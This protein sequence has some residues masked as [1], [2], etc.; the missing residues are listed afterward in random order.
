MAD[1]FNLDDIKNFDTSKYDGEKSLSFNL[2]DIL[3]DYSGEKTPTV[4][5]K[6]VINETKPSIDDTGNIKRPDGVSLTGAFEAI[7]SEKETSAQ[8]EDDTVIV[9]E[10]NDPSVKEEKP[11]KKD[12]KSQEITDVIDRKRFFDTE[13]FN[14]IKKENREL[15]S[16][17]IASFE[18]YTEEEDDGEEEYFKPHEPTEEIDDYNQE[19][20]RDDIMSDLKK[21][22]SSA[23]FK[24]FATFIFMCIS[25]ILF[26]TNY[27]DFSLPRI[28]PIT[29]AKLYIS[30][31]FGISVLSTLININAIITGVGGLFK[32][33]CIPETFISVIFIFNSVVNILTLI[34]DTTSGSIFTF[35]FIY[36]LLLFFNIFSKGIMAKNILKNFRIVSSDGQKMVVNKSQNDELIND[37]MIETESTGDII[38][39]TKSEFVTDFIHKSF[40]DFDLCHRNTMFNTFSL[41]IILAIGII[42]YFTIGDLRTAFIYVTGAFC[43]FTPILQAFS[44]AVPVFNNSRKAR[45]NGGVI[46]GSSSS[47][48]LEDAQTVIVDDSDVFNVT[49][50]GIRL[51][52]DASIDETIIYLNSLFGKVGG[53]LKKLFSDMVTDENISIPRI[54]EIYY[55]ET[56]GYSSLIHSKVFVVGNKQLMNHFGIE[57]DDSDFDIIYQQKNKHVLF[58]AYNGKLVGVF[59]LSYSLC[60]GVKKAFELC[61]Q[62]QISVAIAERDANINISTLNN[63]YMPKD[64][65]LFKIMNFRTARNCF[66]KF[67]AQQK[68]PSLI[69]SNTGLKGLISALRGC[70]HMVFAFK[71]NSVVQKLAS[72]IGLLLVSFLLFFSEPSSLLPIQILAY[73]SMWSLPVLFVSLFSK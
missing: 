20:D 10:L 26:I 66:D 43:C 11:E 32:L 68:T 70:K 37:I 65:A 28:D 46:V 64:S 60:H 6:E 67:V 72:V 41:F 52:G 50:N 9:T 44:F 36:M 7:R 35:D 18:K 1:K 39:A 13:T 3:N 45:K 53:P 42:Y 48:E 40:R 22:S 51:Y 31:V 61:E 73:Q 54:D 56:M 14:S 23:S 57:I 29:D 17:P 24:S 47:F 34:S 59:L 69:T 33:K 49:L 8:N 62:D 4:I 71:V 55:H 63:N 21:M 38:Y 25:G 2:D 19:E 15:F 5:V 27:V 12:L 16:N 30:V 58:V